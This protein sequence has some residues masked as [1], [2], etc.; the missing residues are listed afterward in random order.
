MPLLPHLRHN[1]RVR[2]RLWRVLPI[3]FLVAFYWLGLWTWFY[4]DDFGWLNL[5]RDVHTWTDVL[6]AIFAPQAGHGIVRPLSVT[7]Y[8]L[9]FSTLFGIDPLP[10]RIAVFVTQAGALL[11]LGDIM[12]RLTRSRAAGFW[13]QIFWAANSG[14]AVVMCWT[15]IYNQA[16]CGFF[17]LLAFWCLLRYLET[18]E[19]RWWIAQW[20]AFL[21]GFGA[22]E[23]NVV[24]PALAASYTWFAAR[25]HFRRTL[26]MFAVSAA[27]ALLHLTSAAQPGG[28]YG[29][30]PGLSM[31]AT[32]WTYWIMALGP[33]RLAVVRQIPAWTVVAATLALTAGAAVALLRVRGAWLGL[34]WFI[35][36]LAPF[37]P[38]RDHVM[39]YYLAVPA[40][41]LG[42]LGGWAVAAASRAGIAAK[43]ATVAAAALYLGF[44]LPASHAIVQW[45][46]DRSRDVEKLV[47]GVEEIH[48]ARPDGT[49][50]LTGVT[51][52]LFLAGMAD[53]PFRALNIPRVYLAPGAAEA[54]ASPLAAWF[55]L[56]DALAIGE[57]DAG[58]AA[59]YDASGPQLRN[60]TRRWRTAAVLRS[61][62]P[63]LIIPGDPLYAP[64]LG[65]GWEA[66]RDGFRRTYARATL[67]IGGPRD[68]HDALV[69]G[70]YSAPEAPRV[71]AAGTELRAEA[72]TRHAG[73]ADYRYALPAALAGAAE[74]EI[75]IEGAEGFTFGFAAVR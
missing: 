38:L 74:V 46:Y 49:I 42:M 56:P 51:T 1:R 41:G 47:L 7:G 57:L 5:R 25:K 24:Y 18:G 30:H 17:L 34:A 63:R 53:V 40:I 3:L 58:R 50:L 70:V 29:L 2:V 69:L 37:L 13:A 55:V 43:A 73:R 8:F 66:P 10:F 12:L 11:L 26:P 54:I 65:T 45:H 14:L 72:V 35:F 48:R 36:P 64:Y 21:A 68:A 67:R 61:E 62:T 31:A 22:L 6:P 32:F 59:V 71:R 20:A 33:D 28:V 15:S 39:D 16:L 23:T 60:V 75:A 9:L 4:Q 19:R 44:S 52:D 27:Y